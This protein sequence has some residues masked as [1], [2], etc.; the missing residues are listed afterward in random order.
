MSGILTIA[1]K[2]AE[3]PKLDSLN[4]LGSE[5]TRK[6]AKMGISNTLQF[7]ERASLPSDRREI[8]EKVNATPTDVLEWALYCDFFRLKGMKTRYVRLFRRAGVRTVQELG[9]LSPSELHAKLENLKKDSKVK[10]PSLKQL[11]EWN[12]EVRELEPIIWFE[13]LYCYGIGNYA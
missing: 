10:L 9:L 13:G 1:N 8:A 7:I 2:G 12:R 4:G 3:L 6:L 11:K 5:Y